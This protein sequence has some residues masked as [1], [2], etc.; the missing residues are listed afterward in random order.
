MQQEERRLAARYQAGA[1]LPS[2][3]EVFTLNI[4][5]ED[6]EVRR[7]PE[8]PLLWVLRDNLGVLSENPR[9]HK[10]TLLLGQMRMKKVACL[11]VHHRMRKKENL[12][13]S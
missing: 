11:P 13:P 9:A 10:T 8:T 12:L 4:N 1:D 2:E 6:R 7:P 3:D 5:G